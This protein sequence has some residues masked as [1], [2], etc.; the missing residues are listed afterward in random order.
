M[1]S[2]HYVGKVSIS[3]TSAQEYDAKF[4]EDGLESLPPAA[5]AAEMR[6]RITAHNQRQDAQT[7]AQAPWD[8]Q[9]SP[10]NA[11]AGCGGDSPEQVAIM[12]RD[13]RSV[14]GGVHHC[15]GTEV[16]Q[17]VKESQDLTQMSQGSQGVHKAQQPA[18]SDPLSGR[19]PA[20]SASDADA[21]PGQLG[22][23]QLI[24]WRRY[25]QRLA[26]EGKL[27]CGANDVID[28]C[29][30][31]DDGRSPPRSRQRRAAAPVAQWGMGLS[32]QRPCGG[33]RDPTSGS[34]GGT[35]GGCNGGGGGNPFL[36]PEVGHTLGSHVSN[37][38]AQHSPIFNLK[39]SR[40]VWP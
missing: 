21:A 37:V 24:H 18:S 34:I 2:C 31:D 40:S 7:G 13:T 20:Q 30:S 38:G 9:G 4:D 23:A 8:V 5:R 39:F 32:E 26:A 12:P 29:G 17:G 16:P 10:R 11:Q 25:Q 22:K 19:H 3:T 28:L 33:P 27:D 1:S 6:A 15:S 36:N 35:E 14:K